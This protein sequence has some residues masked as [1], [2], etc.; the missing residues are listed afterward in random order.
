MKRELTLKFK[1][2]DVNIK[3]WQHMKRELT[4]KVLSTW[5][6]NSIFGNNLVYL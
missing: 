3:T 4:F 6:Y 5:D 2:L 1:V